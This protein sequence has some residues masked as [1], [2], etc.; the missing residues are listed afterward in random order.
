MKEYIRF[1]IYFVSCH[2]QK[3]ITSTQSQSNFNTYYFE[4][5]AKITSYLDP[6]YITLNQL[7]FIIHIMLYKW[8]IYNK[9][10]IL[11]PYFSIRTVEYN[12]FC[13]YMDNIY[14]KITKACNLF[15]FHTA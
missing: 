4:Y 14:L 10:I 1:H 6:F 15:L 8:E 5:C 7:K 3:I 13:I 2:S 11:V 12:V 9:Y